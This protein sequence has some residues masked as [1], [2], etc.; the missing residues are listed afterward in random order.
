M[1]ATDLDHLY[2]QLRDRTVGEAEF[3]ARRTA[4]LKEGT[5]AESYLLSRLAHETEPDLQGDV[6]QLLGKFRYQGGQRTS[7]TAAWARRLLESTVVSVRCRALW[8]LGWVGNI[9]D[10]DRLSQALRS[11]ADAENRG[12]AATA[13]MQLHL[14]DPAHGSSWLVVLQSALHQ[15]KDDVALEKILVSIQ[16]ISGKRLGLKA[17]SHERASPEKLQAALKKA[18]KA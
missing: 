16:E 8:A 9:E 7:E 12:W 3:R 11:D 18:L 15:E 17:S 10:L 14:E 5:R 4:F 13:M 2:E 6:L 1:P